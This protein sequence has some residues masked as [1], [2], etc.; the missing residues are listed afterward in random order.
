MPMKRLSLYTHLMLQISLHGVLILLLGILNL[1][2]SKSFCHFSFQITLSH[3]AAAKKGPSILFNNSTLCLSSLSLL[4][5]THTHTL[6]HA[7]VH[8]HVHI[9]IHHN[10]QILRMTMVQ[11]NMLV[12]YEFAFCIRL[13]QSYLLL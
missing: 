7:Q 1:E 11:L 6:M 13:V 5:T 4:C 12:K 2:L 9:C 10:F 3:N 8:S